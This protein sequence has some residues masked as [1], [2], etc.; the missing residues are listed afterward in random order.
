M[1]ITWNYYYITFLSD[2]TGCFCCFLL[3]RP[4]NFS[5]P[6]GNVPECWTLCVCE[7]CVCGAHWSY[8]STTSC[9][10][11]AMLMSSGRLKDN[12]KVRSLPAR[13]GIICINPVT[14]LLEKTPIATHALQTDWCLVA[15]QLKGNYT[16]KKSHFSHFSQIS[17]MALLWLSHLATLRW[18]H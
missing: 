7:H 2:R 6:L 3:F 17:K 9:S 14:I 16:Q 13:I 15:L 4:V 18:M 11:L 1:K 10:P 5:L 8:M 12:L